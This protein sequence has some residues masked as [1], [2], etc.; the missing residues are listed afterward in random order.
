MK[1]WLGMIEHIHQKVTLRA[2]F[3]DTRRNAEKKARYLLRRKAGAFTREDLVTFLEHCNTEKVP[4]DGHCG[5][6]PEQEQKSRFG[7]SFVGQNRNLIV[8][9]LDACNQRIAYLWQSAGDARYAL[10]RFWEEPQVKGAGTGLPTMLMYLCEP[11]T[12][13]VWLPFLA[14]A[15]GILTG[16][17]FPTKL[18]RNRNVDNYLRYNDAVN[19]CLR[20]PFRL[21]PQEIDYILWN[22]G[23]KAKARSGA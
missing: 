8:G 19:E 16:R 4:R 1:K 23:K 20:R 18:R 13:S 15:L 21:K 9:A 14:T 22:I 17:E 10:D 7:P 6:F 3:L 12:F 11:E 5:E 2:E